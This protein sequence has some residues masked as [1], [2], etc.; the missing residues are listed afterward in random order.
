MTDLS[1]LQTNLDAATE[2]YQVAIAQERSART[3]ATDARNKLNEAQKA[4]DAGVAEIRKL[5]PLE[6]DWA[7]ERRHPGGRAPA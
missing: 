6:T 7:E 5:A 1:N 2:K 4:F 3:A